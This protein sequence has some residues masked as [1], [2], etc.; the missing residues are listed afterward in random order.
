MGVQVRWFGRRLAGV[1]ILI[2]L[3]ETEVAELL[4]DAPLL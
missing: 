3:D 1:V 2:E 4:L